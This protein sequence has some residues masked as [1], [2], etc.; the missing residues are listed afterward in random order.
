MTEKTTDTT[1]FTDWAAVPLVLTVDEAAALLR[2]HGNTVR[3]WIRDGRLTAMQVR[4]GWRINKDDVM[5]LLGIE[6]E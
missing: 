3:A 2:V 4:R 1:T 5:R 6:E